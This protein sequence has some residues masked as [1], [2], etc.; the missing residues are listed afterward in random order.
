MAKAL[1]FIMLFSSF[2]LFPLIFLVGIIAAAPI[3]DHSNELAL[4]SR[5]PNLKHL[6][7]AAKV[8]FQIKTKLKPPRGGAV[9]W[10]GHKKGANGP[11]SV[12][13]DAQKYAKDHGKKTLE[14]ALEAKKINIPK[15]K[16]NPMSDKLWGYASKKWAQRAKGQTEAVLGSSLRPASV[17]KTVEKPQLL[18][19]KHVTKITE[20]N[21]DTKTH[22]VTK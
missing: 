9:F 12:Y 5:E 22:R 18:R 10:S 21:V 3:A 13:D 11:T 4:L 15:E 17:W 1:P 19:N 7:Q 6:A 14:M 8:A 16:E 20:H 2:L